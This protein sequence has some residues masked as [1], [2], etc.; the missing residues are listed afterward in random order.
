MLLPQ[1]STKHLHTTL[2]F[3]SGSEKLKV[4]QGEEYKKKKMEEEEEARKTSVV[5]DN[6]S[7]SLCL[8]IFLTLN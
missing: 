2:T 4:L 7:H 8:S 3:V 5:L 1:F 6:H